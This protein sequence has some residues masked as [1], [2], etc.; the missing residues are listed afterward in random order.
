MGLVIH[1]F[2]RAC[3]CMPQVARNGG[4]SLDLGRYP[5]LFMR[6]KEQHFVNV[7]ARLAANPARASAPSPRASWPT[8]HRRT[9]RAGTVRISI[10]GDSA[11]AVSDH[12]VAVRP[13][14]AV[15]SCAK[16]LR[17]RTAYRGQAPGA[18]VGGSQANP[19]CGLTIGGFYYA[20][21]NRAEGSIEG[22]YHDPNS[23]P[24]QRLELSCATPHRRLCCE[25]ALRGSS[26]AVALAG[27]LW[28]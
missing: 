24:F 23:S 2:I 16:V 19:D 10:L 5:H 7:R 18:R 4:R 8:T 26:E 25:R 17:L 15:P 27:K 13:V 1:Y 3:P 20:C 6:W 28:R 9:S 22:F 14:P 21:L 11:C 12:P